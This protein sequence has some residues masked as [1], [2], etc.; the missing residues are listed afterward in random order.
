M[1]KKSECIDYKK[2]D[3]IFAKLKGYPYWPAKVIFASSLSTNCWKNFLKFIL[4]KI[5]NVEKGEKKSNYRY[6]I[7]FYGTYQTY[8]NIFNITLDLSL[9]FIEIFV[10]RIGI[11]LK[12]TL[13]CH[14]RR[15]T[16]KNTARKENRNRSM[17]PCGKLKTIRT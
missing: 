9:K 12:R 13:Y 8:I 7:M 3:K 4:F 1:G 11:Y 16:L 17:T 5:K 14:I 2:G 10:F 6:K 15:R